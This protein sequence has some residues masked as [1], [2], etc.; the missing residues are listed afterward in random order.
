MGSTIMFFFK[1][2]SHSKLPVLGSLLVASV[3][4]AAGSAN[5]TVAED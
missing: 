4:L 2:N 3:L 1:A 5:L